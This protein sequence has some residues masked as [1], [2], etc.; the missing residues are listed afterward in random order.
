TFKQSGIKYVV[1][2]GKHLDGFTLWP[3]RSALNWNAM[4]IGPKR[5][6]FGELGTAVK[7]V[8]LR[9][10][11]YYSLYEWYN[12][13]FYQDY[14]NNFN[15]TF[16]TD[17]KILPELRDLVNKYKPD[18]IWSMDNG[19]IPQKYLKTKEFLTWLYNESPVKDNV[20]VNDRWGAG[21][22]CRHGGFLLCRGRH[23]PNSPFPRKWE[24]AVPLDRS[25]WGFN[26][27]SHSSMYMTIEQLLTIVA[28]IISGG[29]NLL[30][31]VGPTHDGRIPPIMEER[32]LQVTFN[33]KFVLFLQLKLLFHVQFG[34][35][36]N[37][38]S[39]AIYKTE[40]WKHQKDSK[41][42]E[43]YYTKS[44]ENNTI[45]A[46]ILQTPK[47]NLLQLGS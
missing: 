10:G 45:F 41:A 20:V 28:R 17:A 8:G 30:L 31:N 38:N 16:Y 46:I 24:S 15:T 1:L 22:I 29:G 37:I 25:S 7:K 3:S 26:R 2:T 36:L 43:V 4:E 39:I 33:I 23:Q 11:V 12:P 40:Q 14:T 44:K 47:N 34:E 35:W 27:L 42:T 21:S 6:L 9:Y 19:G 13:L 5:D 32:L 18:I